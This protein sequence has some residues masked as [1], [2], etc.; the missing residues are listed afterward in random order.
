[1]WLWC[2]KNLRHGRKKTAMRDEISVML[3]TFVMRDTFSFSVRGGFS[4]VMI[5]SWWTFLCSCGCLRCVC[6]CF[7]HVR[8]VCV[9]VGGTR[10]FRV[11]LMCTMVSVVCISARVVA[12][13]VNPMCLRGE[14]GVMCSSEGEGTICQNKD[15]P[16]GHC[17]SSDWR[18]PTRADHTGVENR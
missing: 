6:V 10:N 15:C 9:C 11:V 14:S 1:M 17:H 5:N 12:V 13:S 8:F 16:L 4:C 7:V 18:L 2:A 3:E